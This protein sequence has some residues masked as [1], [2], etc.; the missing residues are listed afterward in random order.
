MVSGHCQ[1]FTEKEAVE[2]IIAIASSLGGTTGLFAN[3][4]CNDTLDLEVQV[5]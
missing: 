1:L 5:K 4:L 3:I 2:N